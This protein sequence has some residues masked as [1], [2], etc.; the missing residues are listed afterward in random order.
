LVGKYYL[1]SKI[2]S[3]L[4]RLDLEYERSDRSLFREII[5]S[6][7]VAVIEATEYDNWN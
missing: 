5:K 2:S 6:A 1:P 4:Q 7:R 3:Y